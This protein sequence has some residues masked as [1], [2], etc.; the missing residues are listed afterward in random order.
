MIH[1][2]IP[3]CES[4]PNQGLR[5]FFIERDQKDG[6][7]LSIRGRFYYLLLPVI[8][9]P[10]RAII[11]CLA[12]SAP[13]PF[14]PLH[15]VNKSLILRCLESGVLSNCQD[16]IGATAVRTLT[17]IDWMQHSTERGKNFERGQ[18]D[19]K[20]PDEGHRNFQ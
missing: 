17:L 13:N 10:Y 8:S 2:A 1:F 12:R 6:R 18:K 7:P 20:G 5:P 4:G 16:E 11:F 15:S 19:E 9:L 14:E 3:C